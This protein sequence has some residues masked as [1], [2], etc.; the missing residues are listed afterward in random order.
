MKR[1]CSGTRWENDRASSR[2]RQVG[3]ASLDEEYEAL[4]EGERQAAEAFMRRDRAE[5]GMRAG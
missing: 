2:N 4:S 3:P 5:A 1:T